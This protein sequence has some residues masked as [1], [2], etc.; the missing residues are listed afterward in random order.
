MIILED[1]LLVS[2]RFYYFACQAVNKYSKNECI[3]GISL[4]SFAINDH[5]RSFFLPEQDGNDVYFMNCAQ[6]WG[7]VWLRKPWQDFITWYSTHSEEFTE[8]PHLPLS[9]CH[10]PN[11]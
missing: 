3:A 5:T 1:D 4:Y 9:I 6:S 8:Y 11:S 2:P 10:W 7:Q